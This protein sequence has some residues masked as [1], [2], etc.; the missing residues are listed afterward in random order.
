[1]CDRR[2]GD[3]RERRQERRQEEDRRERRQERY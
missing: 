2:E 3:R 1:V